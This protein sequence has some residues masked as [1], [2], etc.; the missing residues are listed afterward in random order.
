MV[1]SIDAEPKKP[2]KLP[3]AELGSK[4]MSPA[5]SRSCKNSVLKLKNLF[6]KKWK[7]N[8][9]KIAKAYGIMEVDVLVSLKNGKK[10]RLS[11]SSKDALNKLIK[12][13]GLGQT[14]EG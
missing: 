9:E 6:Q 12:K 1:M 2:S 7:G 3:L 11:V 5:G 8:Q 10:I 13:F 4:P 14:E